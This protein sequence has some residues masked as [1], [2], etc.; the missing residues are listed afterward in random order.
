VEKKVAVPGRMLSRKGG[1][2]AIVKE[3]VGRK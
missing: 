1:G 2:T 3:I